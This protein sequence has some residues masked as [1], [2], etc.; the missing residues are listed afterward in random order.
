MLL[1][2]LPSPPGGEKV[3]D[4]IPV[5]AATAYAN[6]C[7]DEG[8]IQGVSIKELAAAFELSGL[9]YVQGKSIT[10]AWK[11]QGDEIKRLRKKGK[12]Q[13]AKGLEKPPKH[14]LRDYGDGAF[15]E[16]MGLII[17][18]CGTFKVGTAWDVEN[19]CDAESKFTQFCKGWMKLFDPE[20][21]EGD[22]PSRKV[23]RDAIG[24]IGKH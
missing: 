11:A 4:L 20:R 21:K 8:L 17:E 9:H 19:E 1:D 5:G 15:I 10:E 2:N 22:Y 12:Q 13:A 7:I 14:R 16:V 6:S 24:R 23:F 18:R 3:H